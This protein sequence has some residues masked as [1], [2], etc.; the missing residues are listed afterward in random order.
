MIK[1]RLADGTYKNVKPEHLEIFKQRYP[2]AV[3]VGGGIPSVDVKPK[4]ED[5]FWNTVKNL[6]ITASS[7]VSPMT[8]IPA[9]AAGE[10]YEFRKKRRAEKFAFGSWKKGQARREAMKKYRKF[11]KQAK[12]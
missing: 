8:A 3:R 2:D 5:T 11:R 9:L 4:S 10:V 1:F 6:S 12:V 7:L